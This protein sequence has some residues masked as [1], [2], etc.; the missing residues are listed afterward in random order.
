LNVAEET[1]DG[2]LVV[3]KS[4]EEGQNM[5][6]ECAMDGLPPYY[7]Y[8]Y[9]NVTGPEFLNK[10]DFH[11]TIDNIHQEYND[12]FICC[13]SHFS[14]SLLAEMI[15]HHMNVMCTFIS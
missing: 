10:T 2:L 5:R 12:D 15:C 4:V 3:E 9:S 8:K 7:Y 14:E 11:L 13:Q 1:K 6:Y